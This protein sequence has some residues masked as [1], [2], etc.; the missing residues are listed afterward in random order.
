MYTLDD[1]INHTDRT[2][3][4]VDCEIFGGYYYDD[5]TGCDLDG[6]QVTSDNLGLSWGAQG[7]PNLDQGQINDFADRFN[8][9]DPGQVVDPLLAAT[10]FAVQIGSGEIAEELAAAVLQEAAN[11]GSDSIVLGRV[12]DGYV[13]VGGTVGANTFSI[14]LDVWNSMSADQ[15]WMADV[16]FLQAA[17]DSKQQIIFIMS[18]PTLAPTSSFTYREFEYLQGLGLKLVQDGTSWVVR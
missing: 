2:G 10:L 18:D 8:E 1:P 15:Q 14:P 4:I 9:D 17:V 16:S 7:S 6:E 5:G 3:A 11:L 13:Q 12:A